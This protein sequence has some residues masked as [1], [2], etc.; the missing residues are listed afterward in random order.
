MLWEAGNHGMFVRINRGFRQF[1][2]WQDGDD[3]PMDDLGRFV[4]ITP[5]WFQGI[6]SCLGGGRPVDVVL[7]VKTP[8]GT[9]AVRFIGLPA[10]GNVVRGWAVPQAMPGQSP[11]E[12]ASPQALATGGASLPVLP[13][14][15]DCLPDSIFLLDSSGRIVR[16]SARHAGLAARPALVGDEFAQWLAEAAG[17]SALAVASWRELG[18]RKQLP[19]TVDFT[20]HPGGSPARTR[21]IRGRNRASTSSAPPTW[22]A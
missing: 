5:A 16:A 19:C 8:S 18:W 13:G 17:V 6:V 12:P 22:S 4:S 21:T 20:S 15:E 9:T 10:A 2:G 14:I 11:S 7:P 1:I 3:H